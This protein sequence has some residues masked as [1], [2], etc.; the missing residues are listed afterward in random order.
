MY[1]ERATEAVT[2]Y[3]ITC[4]RKIRCACAGGNRILLIRFQWLGLGTRCPIPGAG[5]NGGI[6]HMVLMWGA[7]SQRLPT[8][9]SQSP[10]ENSTWTA[11]IQKLNNSVVYYHV[12]LVFAFSS[13]L[14]KKWSAYVYFHTTLAVWTLPPVK[15]RERGIASGWVSAM[16]V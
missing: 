2:C 3:R 1:G 7:I 10:I 12:R 8:F 9:N 4:C 16:P 5:W 15:R 11:V 6:A 14:I 13:Y